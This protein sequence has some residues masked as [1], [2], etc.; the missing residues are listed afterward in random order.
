MPASLDLGSQAASQPDAIAVVMGTSGEML[1]Y[2]E[3]DERSNRL[4][5]LFRSRGLSRGDHIAILM[6]NNV[7]YL[8]VAWGAQRAGL[9]YTPL[10][11]HLGT[12][13]IQYILDDCG[14]TALIASALHLTRISLPLAVGGNL[15]G[16]EDY[17]DAVHAHPGGPICDEA[18]G[19]EMLYSSGTTGKPKGV[20]KEL[21]GTP[22]GDPAAVPVQIAA[23]IA[24]SGA[25]PGECDD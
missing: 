14:A 13:E 20:A 9:Y 11:H 2:R 10:N 21:S 16:F 12:A 8:E 1:S 15:A 25:G 7:R 19:R 6:E 4:A 3:L 17:T 24:R 18:E 5:Q 23:N 22:M